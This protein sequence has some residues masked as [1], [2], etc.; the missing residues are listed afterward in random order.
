MKWTQNIEV[1]NDHKLKNSFGNDFCGSILGRNQ[2]SSMPR[3]TAE[4][5]GL[6][7]GW[8]GHSSVRI[9]EKKIVYI[10]PFSEVL[11]EGDEK[12]DLIVSTHAHRDHFDVDAINK[13]TKNGTHVVIK[14]G[15]DRTGLNS[16]FI[17][18]MEIDET[19]KIDD[20][21]AKGVPAYN[22]RSGWK[23]DEHS[24][25]GKVWKLGKD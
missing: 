7:V 16:E 12:A 10:D 3:K 11:K 14:S 4:I 18:E 2:V 21:E 6:T 20:I 15:C 17:K 5:K 13:L 8:L 19:F 23:T 9:Y 1:P 22:V 25:T 24:V